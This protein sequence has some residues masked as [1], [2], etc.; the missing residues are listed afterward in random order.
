MLYSQG[1]RGPPGICRG[2]SPPGP[3]ASLKDRTGVGTEGVLSSLLG[4]SARLHWYGEDLVW[5]WTKEFWICMWIFFPQFLCS[6]GAE[7]VILSKSYASQN[8]ED[9]ETAFQQSLK[10]HRAKGWEIYSFWGVW[11]ISSWNYIIMNICF[12]KISRLS[13]PFDFSFSSEEMT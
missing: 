5:A 3:F 10:M 4:T 8:L 9:T 12:T 1:A 6:P 2:H 7:D 13:D 11:G